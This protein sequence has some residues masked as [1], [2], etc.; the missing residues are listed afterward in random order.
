M[1]QSG[2]SYSI[3]AGSRIRR[4]LVSIIRQPR[5]LALTSACL[6]ALVGIQYQ[7]AKLVEISF[8]SLC[9]STFLLAFCLWEIES[10]SSPKRRIALI[11]LG[12]IVIPSV[13][14]STAF[15]GLLQF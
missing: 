5:K 8:A 12:L 13:V 14:A 6:I 9:I 2:E 3:I 10:L 11:A 15:A 4:E 7:L 1:V